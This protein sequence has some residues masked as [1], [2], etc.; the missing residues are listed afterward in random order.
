MSPRPVNDKQRKVLD[1]LV[2]GG[3]QDPPEPQ[4]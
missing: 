4:T 3:S 2:A 1:W